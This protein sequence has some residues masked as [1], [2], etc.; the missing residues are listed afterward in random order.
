[1]AGNDS[2]KLEL[3]DQQ[4]RAVGKSLT[5]RRA[6]LIECIEDT[7]QTRAVQRL[8]LLELKVIKSVSNKMRSTNGAKHNAKADRA[9]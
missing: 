7:T 6:R 2:V 8:G 4:R 1:M 9:L 3:N 5:E